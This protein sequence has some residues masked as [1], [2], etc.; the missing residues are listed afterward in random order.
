M[1]PESASISTGS[2]ILTLN[3]L[4]NYVIGQHVILTE[5]EVT[6]KS[7]VRMDGHFIR[8]GI[9]ITLLNIILGIFHTKILTH[10]ETTNTFHKIN[11]SGSS[12]YF[13]QLMHN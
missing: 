5:V 2:R 1:R 13:I 12:F 10:D 11:L 9:K 7:C 4:T 6:C 3:P 8:A